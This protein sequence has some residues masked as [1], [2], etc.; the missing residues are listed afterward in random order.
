MSGAIQISGMF[1]YGTALATP[2]AG[3]AIISLEIALVRRKQEVTYSAPDL[4][5]WTPED[6]GKNLKFSAHLEAPSAWQCWRNLR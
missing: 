4:I 3:I 1:E 5:V 2:S 6:D